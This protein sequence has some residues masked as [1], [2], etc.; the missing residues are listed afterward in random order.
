MFQKYVWEHF[1]SMCLKKNVRDNLSA[2]QY[3]ASSVSVVYES[4]LVVSENISAGVSISVLSV[5]GKKILQGACDRVSLAYVS[6]SVVRIRCLNCMREQKK[7][8]QQCVQVYQYCLWQRFCR[9]WERKKMESK[10]SINGYEH[11]SSV[12]ERVS[13][14]CVWEAVVTDTPRRPLI[15]YPKPWS[16]MGKHT[17]TEERVWTWERGGAFDWRDDLPFP[18][19]TSGWCGGRDSDRTH[20]I[21]PD[22]NGGT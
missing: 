13:H 10:H 2:F 22:L 8:N 1:N 19:S 5:S 20:I 3:C 15:Q 7:K 18:V 9:M 4:I 6:L 21:Q 16:H 17:Q 11:F 12:N 14:R